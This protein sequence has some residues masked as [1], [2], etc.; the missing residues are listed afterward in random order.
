MRAHARPRLPPPCRIGT[1]CE[2]ESGA[3]LV[4]AITRP[5]T[6]VWRRRPVRTPTVM[7]IHNIYSQT[8]G[9]TTGRVIERRAAGVA[10]LAED[11]LGPVDHFPYDSAPIGARASGLP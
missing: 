9:A 8:T 4:N 2:E 10:H 7:S 6:N 5:M 1:A 11:L 3:I